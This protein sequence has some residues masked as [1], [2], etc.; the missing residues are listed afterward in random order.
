[1]I[2]SQS[3]APS[4]GNERQSALDV[5]APD[6]RTN[7]QS[8]NTEDDNASE[9]FEQLSLDD[10]R[11]M[12]PPAPVVKEIYN[13]TIG[14]FVAGDVNGPVG[15][16]T[17]YQPGPKPDD[18][19]DDDVDLRLKN[20]EN[21]EDWFF[22][23]TLENQLQV[24]LVAIFAGNTLRFINGCKKWVTS[25]LVPQ[26]SAQEESPSTIGPIRKQ[27]T[28]MLQETGT[29]LYKD[30]YIVESG[31]VKVE[32]VGFVN[33]DVHR[34][35]LN[36]IG[37]SLDIEPLLK[38]ISDLLAQI[39][40]MKQIDLHLMGTP[41]IDLSRSQAA[42]GLG[43]LAKR[44]YAYYL[45]T[46]IRPW[47][48]SRDAFL[49]FTVGWILFAL[50]TEENKRS[51][52]F[53]LLTHWA[54]S[55]N[56][57]FQ[58]TAAATCSRVGLVDISKTLEIAKSLLE[59]AS[60]YALQALR[61][62]LALLY[63]NPENASQIMLRLADWVTLPR[64]E[65]SNDTL[66]DNIPP[67]FL[68]LIQIKS[69]SGSTDELDG[70]MTDGDKNASDAELGSVLWRILE[71][72][73]E[74][75]PYNF[76]VADSITLLLKTCLTHNSAHI[77]DKTCD[78]IEMWLTDTVDRPSTFLINAIYHILAPLYK[79]KKTSQYIKYVVNR[80]ELTNHPVVLQLRA[81]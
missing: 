39:C 11:R 71:Q 32:V 20:A 16:G 21:L 8:G 5:M 42:V 55:E 43:E 19:K 38:K 41:L 3:N 50:A 79:D 69:A 62:S 34:A 54:R 65:N 7:D 4:Q 35:V 14:N 61:L 76:V 22:K 9:S 53:A 46:V 78:A 17:I 56:V 6:E 77:A 47:A 67:V 80:T 25:N 68:S 24:L 23:T 40:T 37:S 57:Y 74:S 31:A 10:A 15:H 30:E 52:V 26:R 28:R 27:T 18:P 36:F 70:S 13:I 2:P 51:R 66:I 60:P 59:H 63:T 58:W 1:M 81:L 72:D 45:S 64:N 49:R 29:G 12:A 33:A 44:N 48:R 73:D 75:A